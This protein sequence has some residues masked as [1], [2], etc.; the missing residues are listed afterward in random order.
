MMARK[1]KKVVASRELDVK[2]ARLLGW[3]GPVTWFTDEEPHDPYMYE[4][5]VSHADWIADK[6]AGHAGDHNCI[7]PR[8]S[9]DY[10]GARMVL[11]RI[12]SLC[13]PKN[14]KGPYGE[15]MLA[16]TKDIGFEGFSALGWHDLFLY[17]LATPE[18]ICRAALPILKGADALAGENHA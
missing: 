4:P 13:D 17:Q 12:A 10:N 6:R 9:S 8:Y 7:V 16:L 5:T 1:T 3:F 11:D 14:L 2:I 15:F 18:Q